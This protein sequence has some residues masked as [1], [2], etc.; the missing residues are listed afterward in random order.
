MDSIP[1]SIGDLTLLTELDVGYY[2]P[3]VKIPETIKKCKRL[4]YLYVDK[5]ILLPFTLHSVNP[6]LKVILRKKG[7]LN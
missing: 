4:E 1:E 6:R 3:M 7:V 5:S 2:G